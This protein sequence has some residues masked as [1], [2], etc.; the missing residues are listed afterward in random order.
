MTDKVYIG[1]GK[2]VR[3]EGWDNSQHKL[4]IDL[5]KI[6]QEAMNH[7]R[8]VTFKDGSVHQMLKIIVQPLR[9]P[10]E[11]KTHSVQV[12]TFDYEKFRREREQQQEQQPPPQQ[13]TA[14]SEPTDDLPF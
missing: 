7:V 3:P 12:D 11:Y 1:G 9:E 5:T 14:D 10:T 4:E 13:R 8:K 6:K 2:E